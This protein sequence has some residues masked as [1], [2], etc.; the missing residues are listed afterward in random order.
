MDRIDTSNGDSS[1]R[2]DYTNML[3]RVDGMLNMPEKEVK[4]RVESKPGDVSEYADMFSD[5]STVD[6]QRF[7]EESL[8]DFTVAPEATNGS[9]K[10]YDI[11]VLDD[12]GEMF[13]ALKHQRT[14]KRLE[15]F[16]DVV[17]LQMDQNVGL[18]SIEEELVNEGYSKNNIENNLGRYVDTGLITSDLRIDGPGVRFNNFIDEFGSLVAKQNYLSDVEDAAITNQMNEEVAQ[19]VND[20]MREGIEDE[21][22]TGDYSEEV[23]KVFN[24]VSNAPDGANRLKVF[25]HQAEQPDANYEEIAEDTTYSP[26]S[27]QA[28]I[29]R[30]R[31]AGLLDQEGE[32][33]EVGEA[34][35]GFAHD[36]HQDYST[37]RNL[38]Q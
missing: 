13:N 30:M 8:E 16:Q 1:D 14:P 10:G 25:M 15:I 11:G 21:M 35:Y 2:M 27:V 34:L 4:G 24:F 32:A 17:N 7:D 3:D 26:K 19:Q 6:A 37:L 5:P 33:T 9:E 23:S 12:I 22:F 28:T 38:N 20:Y 29:S 36:M 18:D 31:S